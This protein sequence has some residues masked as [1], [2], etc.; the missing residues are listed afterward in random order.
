MIF[1]LTPP[2]TMSAFQEK[3]I[4]KD[5][6]IKITDVILF[7]VSG[8]EDQFVVDLFYHMNNLSSSAFGLQT[9]EKTG[10]QSLSL[11]QG[12]VFNGTIKTLSFSL[13]TLCFPIFCR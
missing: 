4:K 3:A 5:P 11:G 13:L 2:T 12:C 10:A 9:S 1:H 6:K 8:E 7:V